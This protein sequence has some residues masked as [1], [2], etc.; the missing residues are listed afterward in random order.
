MV[1]VVCYRVSGK[2]V[3]QY[4]EDKV[5]MI[6]QANSY[7]IFIIK[8]DNPDDKAFEYS[9]LIL[10][11]IGEKKYYPVLMLN[12]S[13]SSKY[14]ATMCDMVNETEEMHK[15]DFIEKIPKNH[16]ERFSVIL[17]TL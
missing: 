10:I 4:Y 13:I 5:P 1:K 12:I 9:E 6:F 11:K 8:I 7:S 17:D 14:C 16:I 15:Y 2:H 3:I